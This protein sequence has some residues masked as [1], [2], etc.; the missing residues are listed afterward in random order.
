M[1]KIHIC[2]ADV[3]KYIRLDRYIL[4]LPLGWQFGQRGAVTAPVAANSSWVYW[5]VESPPN[6]GVCIQLVTK[7]QT[8]LCNL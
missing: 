6:F 4:S 8:K 2:G 7:Y 1:K 5:K 3:S